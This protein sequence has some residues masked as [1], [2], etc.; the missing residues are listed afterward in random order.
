[1]APGFTPRASGEVIEVLNAEGQVVARTEARVSFGGG[2]IDKD[3]GDN[4]GPT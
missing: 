1:M 4:R 2:R 3:T